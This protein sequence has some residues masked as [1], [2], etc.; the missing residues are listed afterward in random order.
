MYG[1]HSYQEANPAVVS[2]VTFPFMFGMMFGD[3]GH[4]SLL[5]MVGIYLTLAT[6]SDP[7]K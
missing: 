7:N 2:V 5:F 6:S 3:I 4:G 1:T